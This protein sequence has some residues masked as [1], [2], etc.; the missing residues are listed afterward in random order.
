[1]HRRQIEQTLKNKQHM[2]YPEL[3]SSNSSSRETGD[4]S[5]KRQRAGCL[6]GSRHAH[7]FCF[8]YPGF[9]TIFTLHYKSPPCRPEWTTNLPYKPQQH[10]TTEFNIN[11]C[12]LMFLTNNIVP[13]SVGINTF[14]K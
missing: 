3:Y 2:R 10:N 12:Y 6:P 7:Y 1:M 4:P 11:G 14:S 9:N 8:W 5:Y 13:P